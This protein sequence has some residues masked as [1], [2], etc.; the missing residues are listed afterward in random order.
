M[1]FE[2]LLKELEK[3]VAKLDDPSTTLDEGLV[4][5]NKGI[6]LGKECLS[7]LNEAK[8]KLALLKQELDGIQEEKLELNMED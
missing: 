5:F 8:G 4:L 3:T 6:E 2:Q 7:A 1:E